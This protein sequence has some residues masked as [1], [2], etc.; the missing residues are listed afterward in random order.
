VTRYQ[1][2]S[3]L[4]MNPLWFN[5]VRQGQHSA[6]VEENG[7][8][9]FDGETLHFRGNGLPPGAPVKVWISGGHFVCA[10]ESDLAR[11]AEERQREKEQAVLAQRQRLDALRDE[12]LAFNE[13]IQLPVRWDV[14]I[15]DV[16][17][18]LSPTSAG[19]GTRKNTVRHI[20]L[21]EG[22][23]AGRLKREPGDLLCTAAGGSNGKQWS[24]IVETALDGEG[25]S[26]APKVTCR[27]CLK[28]AIRWWA[29]NEGAKS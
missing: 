26:Y 13:C 19:D 22:L 25:A 11:E 8:V 24:S 18:G 21:L 4:S 15:K 9:V 3:P 27:A 23:W 7:A 17:S 5:R 14:A 10:T 20:R 2:Q 1:L 16:L 6:T 28:V 12:A 29:A